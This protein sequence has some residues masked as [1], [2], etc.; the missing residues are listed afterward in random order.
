M[1]FC[2]FQNTPLK[3][4]IRVFL[5]FSV[6]FVVFVLN[7]TECFKVCHLIYENFL[8]FCCLHSFTNPVSIHCWQAVVHQ[9]VYFLPLKRSAAISAYHC[10]AFA[11]RTRTDSDS[12]EKE[13]CTVHVYGRSLMCIDDLRREVCFTA[14]IY[15]V[16]CWAYPLWWLYGGNGI[17]CPWHLVLKIKF[18]SRCSGWQ[19]FQF[20]ASVSLPL[21]QHTV[22]RPLASKAAKFPSNHD[23]IHWIF[24]FFEIS[25]LWYFF[26]LS[27]VFGFC[28]IGNLSV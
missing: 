19:P 9:S 12:P 26:G 11:K 6:S 20:S 5:S 25:F 13:D 7:V 21:H 27:L 14:Q 17:H 23:L 16:C 22:F 4:F 8:G 1:T 10:T 3:S 15:G 2:P 18:D 24:L 28:G